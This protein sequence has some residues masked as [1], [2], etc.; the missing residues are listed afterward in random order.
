MNDGIKIKIIGNNIRK[1]RR[2]QKLSQE[3]VSELADISPNYFSRIER[4]EVKS[5][6]AI[7]LLKIAEALGVSIDQLTK[8]NRQRQVVQDRP[9]QLKLIKTLNKMSIDSSEKISK[10]LISI[11]HELKK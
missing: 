6:S 1:T 2:S 5:V 11:I 10:S 3:E 7:N 8:E 4:G 9:N